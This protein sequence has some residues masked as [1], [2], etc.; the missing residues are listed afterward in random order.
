MFAASSI[1]GFSCICLSS[2]RVERW[3]PLSVHMVEA[4]LIGV[5]TSGG[6]FSLSKTSITCS[7]VSLRI[8]DNLNLLYVETSR[9]CVAFLTTTRL[10]DPLKQDFFYHFV[11][12]GA[13]SEERG[14]GK[15]SLFLSDS[16]GSKSE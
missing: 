1:A 3:Q 16:Q 8:S 10:S 4:T 5:T 13:L 11:S 6:N 15:D 14:Y 7:F 9:I 2:F 12:F